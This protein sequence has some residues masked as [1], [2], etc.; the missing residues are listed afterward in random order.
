MTKDQFD[1]AWKE[2]IS[3]EEEPDDELFRICQRNN[4]SM[5]SLMHIFFFGKTK[6]GRRNMARQSAS[7]RVF[8][9]TSNNMYS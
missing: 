9:E 8:A 5:S 7:E 4:L 6:E 1:A 2:L 3:K